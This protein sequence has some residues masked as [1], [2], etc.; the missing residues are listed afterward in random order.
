MSVFRYPDD[1]QISWNSERNSQIL[2]AFFK[3]PAKKPKQ[4]FI[5]RAGRIFRPF[6]AMK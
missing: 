1:M 6:I 2:V 5:S 4:K 3:L